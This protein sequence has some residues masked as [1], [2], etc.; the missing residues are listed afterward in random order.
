SQRGLKPQSFPTP[1]TSNP[2]SLLPP[3]TD[4]ELACLREKPKSPPHPHHTIG[5]P[6]PRASRRPQSRPHAFIC[7]ALQG[8]CHHTKARGKKEIIC[9]LH[10]RRRFGCG[11]A[12]VP[13][14][15]VAARLR[16]AHGVAAAGRGA[17]R[18]PRAPGGNQQAVGGPREE[19]P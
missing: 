19:P 16:P 9:R 4:D 14:C 11:A 5:F 13:L 3:W 17:R 7:S 2:L 1:R 18:R 8:H 10:E 15:G 12:G 6:T